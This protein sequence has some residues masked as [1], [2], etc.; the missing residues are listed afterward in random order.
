M[1]CFLLVFQ[2]LPTNRVPDF[3]PKNLQRDSF[4]LR[5]SGLAEEGAGFFVH[6]CVYMIVCLSVILPAFILFRLSVCLS[7]IPCQFVS[8]FLSVCPSV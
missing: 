7:E 1:S 3:H 2:L 6:L 8:V 4:K 5:I